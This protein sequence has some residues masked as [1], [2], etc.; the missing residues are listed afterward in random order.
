LNLQKLSYDYITIQRSYALKT[1]PL[2]VLSD[3]SRTWIRL[4]IERLFTLKHSEA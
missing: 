3:I 1:K 4:P 2:T